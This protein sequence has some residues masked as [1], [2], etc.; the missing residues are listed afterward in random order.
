VL[1]ISSTSSRLQVSALV[2]LWLQF[3]SGCKYAMIM[4][5]VEIQTSDQLTVGLHV[6]IVV[7]YS[8]KK[9]KWD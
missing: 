5:N 1:L 6:V 3:P 9:Y 8:A 4:T 2:Y 7:Q